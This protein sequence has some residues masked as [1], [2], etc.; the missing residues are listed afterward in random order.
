MP[1]G[2]QLKPAGE[3]GFLMGNLQPVESHQ[4]P[5][6][7]P[8]LNQSHNVSCHNTNRNKVWLNLQAMYLENK[9]GLAN[10]M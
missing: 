6:L 3:L 4:S 8:Y 5:H 1:G 10:T 2:S 7:L 9:A